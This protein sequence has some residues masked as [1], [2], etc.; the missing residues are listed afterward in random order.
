M[1]NNSTNTELL[2]RFIDGELENDELIA[3][4]EQLNTDNSLAAELE[5]LRYAKD[6]IKSYGIRNTVAAVH[7]EMMKEL[8]TTKTIARVISLKQILKYSSRI[9]AMAILVLGIAML[10]QYFS[11][12][13]DQLFRNNYNAF[14]LH[15]SR[16]S[17]DV[18]AL[19][20]P[21]KS[22]DMKTT[23]KIFNQLNSP[24]A[25][26]YFLNG[27]AALQSGN[28]SAAIKSFLALQQKN[29][30]EN[31]HL[32]EEDTQYYLALAYLQN[33]DAASALPIFE[34]IH[35]D[36]K[37]PYYRQAGSWFITKLKRLATEK[38]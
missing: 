19:E 10:Y 34:N 35:A 15:E 36:N 18:S 26:D 9:A 5:N 1:N 6:A 25:E 11:A 4:K 38:K 24:T 37:H 33:N 23:M 20:Q 28:P 27:N 21:Y 32:F 8:N 13:P 7:S 30:S 12:T 29:K 17:T 22:G 16:G 14:V 3:L 31:T 2:I